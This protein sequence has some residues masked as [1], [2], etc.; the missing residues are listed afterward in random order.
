[1]HMVKLQCCFANHAL[2]KRTELDT[3]MQYLI[4]LFFCIPVLRNTNYLNY[5]SFVNFAPVFRTSRSDCW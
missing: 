3:K 5:Y 4:M 2:V 1:M